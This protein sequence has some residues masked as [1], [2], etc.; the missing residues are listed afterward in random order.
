M[1][2]ICN[3]LQPRT[4]KIEGKTSTLKSLSSSRTHADNTLILAQWNFL[5]VVDQTHSNVKILKSK[6]WNTQKLVYLCSPYTMCTSLK[7][8]YYLS[9]P[10]HWC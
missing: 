5:Y 3:R 8:M 10:E 4:H 1:K 7:M 6:K 9:P 2:C